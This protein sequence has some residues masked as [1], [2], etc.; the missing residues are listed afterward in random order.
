[1]WNIFQ[2]EFDSLRDYIQPVHALL[3]RISKGDAA[4]LLDCPIG[5]TLALGG[6]SELACSDYRG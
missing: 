3:A 6:V 5:S 4:F 1:M 2:L